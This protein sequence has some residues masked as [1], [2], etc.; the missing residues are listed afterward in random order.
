LRVAVGCEQKKKTR[1]QNRMWKW[2]SYWLDLYY[3]LGGRERE[4]ERERA[5]TK[6][7]D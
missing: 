5:L 3:R 6:L 1:R 4:G 7:K 2:T